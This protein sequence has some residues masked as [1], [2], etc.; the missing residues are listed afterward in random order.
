MGKGDLRPQ[1]GLCGQGARQGLQRLLSKFTCR[2]QGTGRRPSATGPSAARVC[3][4]CP[5][6]RPDSSSWPARVN[7]DRAGV[8]RG[9]AGLPPRDWLRTPVPCELHVTCSRVGN[10]GSVTCDIAVFTPAKGLGGCQF[11]QCFP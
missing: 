9:D 5:S 4:A 7:P 11:Y 1:G 10:Y 6:L 3:T 8:P 2:C